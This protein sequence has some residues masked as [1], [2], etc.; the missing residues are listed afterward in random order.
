V[1]I[2][3]DASSQLCLRYKAMI[4]NIDVVDLR[5]TPGGP[6]PPPTDGPSSS[7]TGSAPPGGGPIGCPRPSTDRPQAGAAQARRLVATPPLCPLLSTLV[8]GVTT[9]WTL[10]LDDYLLPRVFGGTYFHA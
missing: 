9:L 5:S 10:L 2:T 3:E 6:L 1:P 4:E 7:S 8:D